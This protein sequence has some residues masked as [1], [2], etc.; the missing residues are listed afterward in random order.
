MRG[1]VTDSK[2]ASLL[3]E[4]G[5]AVTSAAGR[6]AR[7]YLFGSYARGD[8]G[9]YSDVDLLVILADEVASLETEDRVRDAIYEF[10]LKSDYILSAMVVSESQA[11]EMSGVGVFA[12]V[13]REGV[14]I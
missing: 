13:E 1:T 5:R 2:L 8:A 4:V 14:A 10:S 9:Q 3:G 6:R 12:E 7:L 11:E